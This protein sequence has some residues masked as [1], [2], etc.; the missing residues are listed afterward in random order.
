MLELVVPHDWVSGGNNGNL[1]GNMVTPRA[2][3]LQVALFRL[4][5]LRKLEA[6]ALVAAQERLRGLEEQIL[7]ATSRGE[8]ARGT[9][10]PSTAV[11]SVVAAATVVGDWL[12]GES[13]GDGPVAIAARS[14]V[15]K[16]ML[17]RP[18]RSRLAQNPVVRN[19]LLCVFG[20]EAVDGAALDLSG[21]FAKVSIFLRLQDRPIFLLQEEFQM[22]APVLDGQYPDL[23]VWASRPVQA[24]L[25]E[26]KAQQQQLDLRKR[27][28]KFWTMT[29]AERRRAEN[30]WGRGA[31]P[32]TSSGGFPQT[33]QVLSAQ[34]LLACGSR[35]HNSIVIAAKQSAA[36]QRPK[37]SAAAR[38]HQ[39]FRPVVAQ[40]CR[41][42]SVAAMMKACAPTSRTVG[43]FLVNTHV[44]GDMPAPA[45]LPATASRA[46]PSQQLLPF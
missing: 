24:S 17:M 25:L 45:P 40:D 29:L 31:M 23:L 2:T 18:K 41:G 28:L 42:H 15:T 10:S 9:L 27:E 12:D 5:L 11:D 8:V 7:P 19:I 3:V 46:G 36:G 1:G 43:D 38:R 16:L 33:S 6:L 34:L 44:I 35:I 30:L 32:L 39:D 21:R 4:C 22:P 13:A 37:G 20:S 26:E 14:N